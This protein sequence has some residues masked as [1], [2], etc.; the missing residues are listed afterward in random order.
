MSCIGGP[1]GVEVGLADATAVDAAAADGAAV[2]TDG[3]TVGVVWIAVA[4][5]G[6]VEPEEQPTVTAAKTAMETTAR[7]SRSLESG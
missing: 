6:K 4:G 2:V 5:A 3:A 7:T 1:S